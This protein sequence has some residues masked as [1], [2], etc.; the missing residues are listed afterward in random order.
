MR[1]EAFPSRIKL[2][3]PTFHLC[4]RLLSSF[5][6]KFQ[7]SEL[8]FRW[9]CIGRL[10]LRIVLRIISFE[11]WK[12]KNCSR[13][14]LSIS[15]SEDFVIHYKIIICSFTFWC[16]KYWYLS[17]PYHHLGHSKFDTLHLLLITA[18]AAST[19]KLYIWWGIIFSVF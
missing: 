9:F 5:L 7:I 2:H 1:R 8:T 10:N 3:I 4:Q 15:V 11:L 12:C 18:T 19:R 14:I 16:L 17:I 13:Q 6:Y